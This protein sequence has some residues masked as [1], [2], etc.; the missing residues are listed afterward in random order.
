MT[1]ELIDRIFK[2]PGIKYELTE[3]ETLGK[4]I[5][6]I[7]SIYPKTVE[8]GRDAGKVKYYLKSFAPFSSGKEE[9]QVH[10]EGGKSAPE[11][12]VRQ[13]WVYKLIH[14]YGYQPDEIDLEKSV[15]FG[16]EVGT[17]ATGIIVYTDATKETP[18]IIVE[19]KKPKRKDGNTLFDIPKRGQKP[20]DVLE[21]KKTLLQLK[22]EFNFKEIIQ[23][24]E[25]LVLADSGKDEFNEIFKLIFAKIWDE[26]QAQEVRKDK[27]VEFGQVIN[28]KTNVPDPELTYDRTNGLFKKACEEWPGIFREGE[29]IELMKR[30]L[31]ICVGRI[32]GVRLMGS[33]LRIMD[34]AFEYLLPTEAKKKKGHFSPLDMW[35][36]CACACSTPGLPN[37]SWTLP[38]DRAGFCCMPWTGA[39]RPATLMLGSCA[40]SNTLPSTFGALISK[41]G[42][43]RRRAPSCSL[44]ATA[45]PISSARM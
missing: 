7:L 16:G 40:N 20:K 44:R 30:H 19:C 14:Q 18:K 34:D 37:M 4:P 2:E 27:T 25:E 23:G 5:H 22:K 28:P 11:E 39:T 6:E 45:T 31:Q 38:A 43:P 41:P 42:P 36:K 21:A 1:K 29:D 26:K 32:E 33:N 35:L 10:V 3:F 13:L 24:L 15:Q 8:I 9:V 17:K 12:I